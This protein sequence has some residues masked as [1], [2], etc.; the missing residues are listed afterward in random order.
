MNSDGT[1]MVVGAY[2]DDY[3]VGPT[4]DVGCAYVYLHDGSTWVQK[5]KIMASDYE[6]GSLYGTKVAIDGNGE[7][8]TVCARSDDATGG[9]DSGAVYAYQASNWT[10][11]QKII[12]SDSEANAQFGYSCGISGDGSCAIVGANNDDAT[13]G[14][15]SGAAYVFQRT[16]AGWKESWGNFGGSITYSGGYTYHT[17]TTSGTLGIYSVSTVDIL[18][19][20]GGGGGALDFGGGGGGGRVTLQSI[21]NVTDG[22]YTVTVGAGGIGGFVGSGNTPPDDTVYSGFTGG[23]SSIT[24]NGTTYSAAG[25]KGGSNGQHGGSGVGGSSSKTIE[26]STTN[27][28]GGAYTTYYGG[29]GAGAGQNGTNGASGG[30]GGAGVT[31]WGTTYGGGGGGGKEYNTSAGQTSGGVGGGGAGGRDNVAAASGTNGLGGGGGSGGG[32]AGIYSGISGAGGSGVV[33][34]RYLT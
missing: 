18:V 13:G 31:V 12:P 9:A 30:N 11:E 32:R 21:V 10:Q 4:A 28:T 26:G 25:G 29:G 24:I 16:F 17:F 2:R 7:H 1:R 5:A 8:I 3:P 15:D 14:A 20:G 34:V 22:V 6:A 33:I 27:Y 19:V 23:T